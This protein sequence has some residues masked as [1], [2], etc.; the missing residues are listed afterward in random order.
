MREAGAERVRRIKDHIASKFAGAAIE[1]SPCPHM[2]VGDF[3]PDDVFEDVL[4]LN[5]FK[6]SEGQQWLTERK[7]KRTRTATPYHARRQINFHKPEVLQS[8]PAEYREFW[9]DLSS[10]FL[11]DDWFPALVARKYQPYF[12]IRFGDAQQLDGFFRLF[13]RECFLQ[14]HRRGYF[15]GPHTD[16]PQ[17]VFTC[18][19][20]FADRPGFEE[21]GT[22]LLAPI[23]PLERCYGHDHYSPERFRV[24]KLAPY[25]PNSF[26]L[27]FKTR[28]SFH[29]VR[30]IHEGVPN[31]RYGMQF[32]FYETSDGI[33]HELSKPD[34]F[35]NTRIATA[36]RRGLARS[37]VNVAAERLRSRWRR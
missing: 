29:A 21:F 24:V 32:Q 33:F 17:R 12:D 7:G 25:R 22:E 31:E 23:D 30:E 11:A 8:L 10:V 15:I 14:K 2:I 4:R 20:S 9:E 19:F 5:V 18:I 16:V 13:R 26:L 3:L 6:I 27:F 36:E 28:Q 37:V 35:R 34:L 1:S